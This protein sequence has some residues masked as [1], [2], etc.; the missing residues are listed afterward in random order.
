MNGWQGRVAVR[1]IPGRLLVGTVLLTSALAG[2]GGTPEGQAAPPSRLPGVGTVTTAPDG[3]QEV[4]IQTEDDYAF[5]PNRFTVKP[6]R[7]RLTVVNTAKQLTHNF[8]FP[9]GKGP[10]AI[11]EKIPVL[12][13]GE[14][15]TIQFTVTV[16][17]AYP[18]EC[19]FHAM[20]GQ[21]GTMT[22]SG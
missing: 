15:Q 13:P 16:P 14:S 19:T 12:A 5:T 9:G 7:V 20:L 3:V 11:S 10:A 17:G 6:G 1:G 4:T 18:F 2:C 21:V 22:V 8:T